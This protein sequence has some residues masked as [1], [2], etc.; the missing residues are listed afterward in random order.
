M[1]CQTI[2]KT[3][4]NARYVMKKPK[5]EEFIEALSKTEGNLTKTAEL[6]GCQRQTLWLWAKKDPKFDSAIKESRKKMLD[7]CITTAR[8][9]ARG[10]PILDNGKFVGWEVP[11]DPQMLRYFISTLGRDEGFGEKLDVTTNGKDLAAP[12]KIEV[13]T[14]REQVRSEDSEH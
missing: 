2:L 3:T 6:L 5:I 11:P 13:I 4:I 9:V 12:I 1:V 10:I 8:L 7:Q 14:C